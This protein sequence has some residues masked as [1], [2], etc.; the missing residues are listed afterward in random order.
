MKPP[1]IK[2]LGILACA[3]LLGV[4]MAAAESALGLQLWSLNAQMKQDERAALDLVK[5]FGLTKVETAGTGRLTPEAFRGLLQERGLQ[6][7][8]GH[9]GYD[10]FQKDLP[11]VLREAQELGLEFVIC[12]GLPRSVNAWAAAAAGAVARSFDEWG[13][14]ARAAGL[15]F[16]FHTHGQE[17]TPLAGHPDKT[18]FD[19][20][21]AETAPENVCFEMDV[22]WAVHAGRDPVALL[23]R[24]PGRWLLLHV[25]DMRAGAV[26]GLFSG[27]AAP[28]DN[29]PVGSG[30]IDWPAL[31]PAAQTAGVRYFFIEDETPAPLQ[32][33]PASLR[34][35]SRFRL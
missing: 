14:A 20:L 2:T 19:V 13:R 18:V 33:I 9:F 30:R 16:G 23:A 12:P 8:A 32:S 15:R 6:P 11:G 21:V 5:R 22:F 31:L 26:T 34:Y 24:H 28:T 4:R 7:V 17:F 25:K 29:V 3:G 1:F 10:R 35:L 27:H